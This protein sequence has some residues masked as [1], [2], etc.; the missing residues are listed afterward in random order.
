MP[1]QSLAAKGDQELFQTINFADF[2]QHVRKVIFEHTSEIPCLT[3]GKR[4]YLVNG[5]TH[6]FST[7]AHILIGNYC[8]LSHILDFY[9][10]MNHNY[11]GITS[12]PLESVCGIS[13]ENKHAPN[14]DVPYNHHQIIIGHDVWIGGNVIIMSGVHIG[15]GAVIGAGSVVAKD[16][17]PYAIA[18]GNPARIIKY[19]FDKDTITRLQRIKWWNWPQEDVE[20]HIPAFENDMRSFLDRFD[21]GIQGDMP[22]ETA[23]TI[24]MLRA[25]GFYISYFIPDVEIS[26]QYAVWPRVIDSFLMAYTAEDKAALMLAMP[27]VEGIEAYTEAIAARIREVGE[28]APLILSHLCTGEIPF[29]T[30]ALKASNAYI[31]T[32]EAV[33]SYAV[34]DASDARLTIHYGLDQGALIFPPV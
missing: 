23:E 15:N 26:P 3:I 30:A 29:S 7:D 10:G 18:V 13:N 17:P 12:Y 31:T 5:T 34:D 11:H 27:N 1:I 28:R 21:P 6:Y 14:R 33:C 19:R 22:D 16:V 2:S 20:R 4:S 24:Q 8:S 9:M 32:R 25:D